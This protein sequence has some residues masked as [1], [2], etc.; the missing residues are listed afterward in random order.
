MPVISN[1]RPH[2]N[3]CTYIA[4]T[5]SLLLLAI[6]ASSTRAGSSATET[7]A[8]D[9]SAGRV[10]R[11]SIGMASSH[12]EQNLKRKLEVQFAGQGRAGASLEQPAE[13]ERLGVRKI[14]GARVIG[15]DIFF[16]EEGNNL[17]VDF[18]SLGIACSEIPE[19]QSKL[20]PESHLSAAEIQTAS[21]PSPSQKRYTW[22]VEVKPTCRV[23]L[24]EA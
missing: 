2:L 3:R 8:K 5:A 7:V 16:I 20:S 18:V 1:V 12:L 11:L 22:S 15:V 21:G 14:L 10:G 9:L 6:A 17:T 13:L 23:W 19:L 4:R 24:R